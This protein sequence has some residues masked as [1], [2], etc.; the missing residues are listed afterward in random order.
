MTRRIPP[1]NPLRVFEVVARTENLTTAA[2]EL[3]VTQSAVSRQVASLEDY[4]GVALFHRERHG[5]RL[6]TAGQAY[7]RE[8]RPAFERIAEA[9]RTLV[10]NTQQGSLRLRTY[11]TFAAKWLIPRLPDFHRRHP[12]IEVRLSTGVPDVD[13]D[14]DPVDLAVQFGDGHWPRCRADLLFPDEI[15]PV[16]APALLEALQR[17]GSTDTVALLGVRRLVSQYRRHDWDDWLATLPTG[18]D[19]AASERMEFSSSLLTWQAAIDGLGVAIGQAALL[20]AEFRD[21]RLVRPFARPLVR[22]K[23]HYLVRPA[24][25]RESAK[26]RTFRQWLLQAAGQ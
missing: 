3:H 15:E 10:R 24:G 11:S 19:G 14:R 9:T 5:V 13:F 20:E 26:V 21:G 4:L 25:Q 12:G 23:G 18:L 8:I 2:L 16:C 22:P 7:A 6:T 17:Q 1:L